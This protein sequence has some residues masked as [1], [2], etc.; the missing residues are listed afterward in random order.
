M[1]IYIALLCFI[2]LWSFF[3]RFSSADKDKQEKIILFWSMA[4]IFL[5]L[6][7]KGTSVGNDTLGY[8]TQYV[9]A[10]K[11]PWNDFSFN[12]FEPGF[13]FLTKLFS[14]AGISF[15]VF[16]VFYSG[17]CCHA[18]YLFIRK[19]SKN[20]TLSLLIFVCYQFFVFTISGMRQALAMSV[21]LYAFLVLEKGRI[22]NL[23]FSLLIT[24][25]ASLLH[26]S[27]MVFYVVILLYLPKHTRTH[28]PFYLIVLLASAALR[29]VI[30]L[31]VDKYIRNVNMDA[32][33]TL[34][35]NFLFLCGV[36]LFMF[37]T[38]SQ[39]DSSSVL[40]LQKHTSCTIDFFDAFSL[41]VIFALLVGNVIFSGGTTLR[42][43]M[44]FSLFLIPAL[45]NFIHYYE[46]RARTLLNL[47]LGF[48]LIWLF[49][50]DVLEPNQLNLCP[51]KFFWEMTR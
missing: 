40:R 5:L 31:F 50:T 51:Y 29:P 46:F 4:L 21:C 2:L 30:W 25:F 14:K 9:L 1:G 49:Y 24:Y 20:V 42:A 36:A 26:Q 47:A 38:A 6:A 43:M 32:V 41:R 44:F 39:F 8:R 11:R 22:L 12:Y 45:P 23:L 27:A 19:H 16:N 18:M 7:L 10:G 15:Q 3:V 34:N 28:F 35:G 13:L 37:F 33:I 17:I 48:F